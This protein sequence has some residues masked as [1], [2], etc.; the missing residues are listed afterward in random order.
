[1]F[2][3]KI[4]KWNHKNKIKLINRSMSYCEI[5]PPNNNNGNNFETLVVFILGAI[6]YIKSK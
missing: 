4:I 3:T 1:M 6:C 2:A 5:P